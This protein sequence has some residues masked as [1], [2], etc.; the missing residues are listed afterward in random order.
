LPLLVSAKTLARLCGTSCATI[1]RW[2]A[3][4]KLPAPVRPTSGTT[5]WRQTDIERWIVLGCPDR[6]T[7]ET[8]NDNGQPPVKRSGRRS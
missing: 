4:A 3:A 2:A 1:W 6:Q 5:R 7:F 8:T